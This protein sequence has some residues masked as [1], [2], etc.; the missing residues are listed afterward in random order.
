M[1][2]LICVLLLM[3]CAALPSLAQPLSVARIADQEVLV[4]RV[5]KSACLM[6]SGA[7]TTVHSEDVQASTAALT[8]FMDVLSGA[9]PLP[10]D[11]AAALVESMT[12]LKRSALQIRAG[13]RHSVPVALMLRMNIGL[14]EVFFDMRATAAS[15]V[16]Y[17]YVDAYALVQDL[18]IASQAFQ[19]DLCLFLTELAAPG[20]A[21]QMADRLAV[22]ERAIAILVEGDVDR[23]IPPAPNIHI[24]ITLGKV[25][26][27]WQT[28][29][30]I[31][32]G[33]ARGE[34]VAAR[35]AQLASVLGDAM[36]RDLDNI[37]ERFLAL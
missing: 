15:P 22:F 7:E 34:P 33:A 25:A 36:L 3:C 2:R 21:A 26:A 27:K 16:G 5:T 30:P 6:L 19:R 32:E 9:A 18:R 13:D 11:D 12:T 37:S 23:S 29:A 10:E 28:L 35:D 17:P 1:T 20:A 8:A 14:S 24:K 4:H 31:L